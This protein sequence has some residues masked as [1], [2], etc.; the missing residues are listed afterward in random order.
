L[1]YKIDMEYALEERI[2]NPDLFTGRKKELAF[3]LKW[4]YDIKERKSK[5]TAIL[6]RRKMGKS[7]LMERLFN[8]TFYKNDRII[9]FFYEVKER[10]MWVKDFCIDFFLTF[11]YQYI[12][13]KSRKTEYLSSFEN[14][15]FESA[16]KALTKE[17]LDFLLELVHSV[18]YSARN[19]YLDILWETVRN[20]PKTIAS[21]K[22]E[23]IVQMIDEF[24][25]LNSMIYWDQAKTNPADDLAGGYL[26]T[27]ESKIAPLLVSGSWV[28]WLMNLLIMML[29]SRFRFTFLESM[30]EDE[31]IEMIFKYSRFFDVPVTDE[32]AYLISNLSEG[33]PFYISSILRSQYEHKDLTDAEGLVKTL[34]F[35][36]LNDRGEIKSTWMEYVA[37][38]FSRVNDKNA[39]NIVLYLCKNRDREVTRKELLEQLQLDMTDADLEIKLKALVKAD[40]IKQGQ[41]YYRYRGVNDN[42][43]D[44]VFRGVYQE[45]I[46]LFEPG[47][48]K[49]EYAEAF[50]KLKKEYHSLQ[51]KF[52][53]H[54]GYFA[55]YLILDQL[56]YHAR[57]R[58]ELLKSITHNL[59]GDFD[60]CAYES[61]W[62][63]N[64][65][66]EYSRGLS[67]DI[68]ARA[69]TAGNYSIIGEVKNR[70]TK[71]FSIEEAVSFF[72]KLEKIKVNEKLAP[73]VGF[74]FSRTGFT[75]EAER[76]LQEKGIAYS[77]DERWLDI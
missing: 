57:E 44:K 18:E 1:W 70:D 38:A 26:S 68:L 30:P 23:Y 77:E 36:T 20:A 13:F 76:Y 54:K 42:I 71:K 74:V 69:K 9:P 4:I 52:N 75:K 59:P 43:F 35:E 32:T 14:N 73:M 28:G 41:S 6:A 56:N 66:I 19:D 29:P 40:I 72:E 47:Q 39:K 31:S 8:I 37:S 34:E 25:F 3:F 12:A 10:K 33:S 61:V 50:D 2:G 63:Y 15:D 49:K 7:A 24:Q 11:I 48:I 67:V 45:E 53:Y 62:K 51:G 58:S 16:K 5:S 46:E 21:R 65:V 22:E 64:A 17:G 27:A 60:F 55:E